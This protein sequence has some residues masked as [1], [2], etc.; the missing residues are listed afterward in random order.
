MCRAVMFEKDK[1]TKISNFSS[2]LSILLHVRLIIN[3]QSPSKY[4]I[5]CAGN[6]G[7]EVHR[8]RQ[9]VCF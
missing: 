6:N 3:T 1:I 9:N 4:N 7:I 5:S 2:K 8:K